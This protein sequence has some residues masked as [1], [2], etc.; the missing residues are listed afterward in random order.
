MEHK[1]FDTAN[2]MAQQLVR[3][4]TDPNEVSKALEY[5]V[6]NKDRGKFFNLLR[7]IEENGFVV[8]RSNRT[9]GYY[10]NILRTCEQYLKDYQDPGKMSLILG[11]AVRLMRYYLVS[12]EHIK[13]LREVVK[14]SS[15]KR[16]SDLKPG[17][18]LDGVVKEIRPYGAFVDIGV[19]RNGLLHISE[20][21]HGYVKE[22]TDI[23][24]IG[25]AVKVKVIGVNPKG[26]RINLSMKDMLKPKSAVDSDYQ[27]SSITIGDILGKSLKKDNK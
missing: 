14:S 15:A 3:D 7:T 9:I 18:V 16:L 8:I 1:D 17:M 23:V 24:N 21:A 25:D 13:P 12:P 26:N 19:G 10:R 27:R 20:I 6:A 22:V 5:L 2:K 11:W 4:D